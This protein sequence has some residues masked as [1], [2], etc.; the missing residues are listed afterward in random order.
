[1]LFSA[2]FKKSREKQNCV[3]GLSN[4]HKMAKS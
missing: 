2:G 4:V 3:K 1:M